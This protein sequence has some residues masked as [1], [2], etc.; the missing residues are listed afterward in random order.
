MDEFNQSLA[1]H[2]NRNSIT[3]D[4]KD[5]L[6]TID[7]V[8]EPPIMTDVTEQYSSKEIIL[9]SEN[10]VV[11]EEIATASENERSSGETNTA[12]ENEENLTGEGDT[13]HTSDE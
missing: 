2:I 13:I 11:S 5:N 1:G 7:N 10:V 8:S 3:D 4:N 6:S 12:E 9:T